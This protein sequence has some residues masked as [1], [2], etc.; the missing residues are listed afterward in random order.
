MASLYEDF[1]AN[2]RAWSNRDDDVLSD[3]IIQDALS[4]T[5]DKAYKQLRIPSLEATATYT[6]ID[7]NAVATSAYQVK[8]GKN[9]N[10]VD[11]PIPSDLTSFIMLRI[12]DGVVL[13]EKTDLRTFHDMYADHYTDFFWARQGSMIKASGVFGVGDEIELHYYRR[14]PKLN[15][16]YA[17]TANNF[18]SNLVEVSPIEATSGTTLFFDSGTAYPP[19]PLS[20]T[21]YEAQNLAGNRVEFLFA[22]DSGKELPHWLRDE[23]RQILLFGALE[24]CFDYLDDQPQAQ[25][26]KLKFMEAIEELNKEERMRVA[27][28]GNT[29]VHF[30][31]QLI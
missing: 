27:S 22:N 24:Q 17:V 9:K 30:N 6:I 8:L 21:A 12:V 23:N 4:Y 2:V 11:L 5:A 31:S 13:N 1:V 7:E 20:D 15:A 16:H 26:F 14:L 29:Q 19:V 28:G 25:K 3:E 10:T 18:N